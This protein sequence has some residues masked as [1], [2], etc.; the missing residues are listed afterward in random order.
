MSTSVTAQ[1]GNVQSEA[2]STGTTLQA[3]QFYRHDYLLIF[4][5]NI[6]HLADYM[7][8]ILAVVVSGGVLF[9]LGW[10]ASSGIQYGFQGDALLST[11]RAALQV[12]L[13]YPVLAWLS[14]S[15]PAELAKLFNSLYDNGVIGEYRADRSG[16][17]TYEAF[18]QKFV[19]WADSIWWFVGATAFVVVYWIYQLAVIEP[20][21]PDHSG[22]WFRIALVG[23]TSF[24]LY[25]AFYSVVRILVAVVFTNWLF[26]VFT[27]KVNP[28]HPDGSAGLGALGYMLVLSVILVVTMGVA[29]LVM[30]TSILFSSAIQPSNL[31]A[32]AIGEA[33]LF[34]AL[35]LALAPS[36]LIA[37]LT[38]PHKE[39]VEARND[40]LLPL[41]KEFQVAL[42]ET[43]PAGKADANAIKADNDRLD[44]LKRRYQ[45]IQDTYPTYPLAVQNVRRLAATLT[46]PALLPILAPF[47]GALV[48]YLNKTVFHL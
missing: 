27:I 20:M 36:L 23:V 3:Q 47:I 8:V 15:L 1:T 24:M 25:A 10:F 22:L 37:W 6:L 31:K 41:S 19:A 32:F 26:N 18:L 13:I 33:I 12:F 30:N 34:G 14:I 16:K 39:M 5:K 17:L 11:V 9:G 48:T 21:Q 42:M 7:I 38:L 2:A 29:A 35:Y 45:L 4:F 46:F 44:Q 28:L 40:A 43:D